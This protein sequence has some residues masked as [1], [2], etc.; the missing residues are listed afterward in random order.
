MLIESANHISEQEAS[1]NLIKKMDL[2]AFEPARKLDIRTDGPNDRDPS[3]AVTNEEKEDSN[4][5]PTDK[6]VIKKPEK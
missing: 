2:A 3:N 6:S 5:T 4:G 1:M